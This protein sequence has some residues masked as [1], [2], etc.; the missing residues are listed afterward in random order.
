MSPVRILPGDVLKRLRDLPDESVHCVVTSPPY[1]GLRN[2]GI[3]PTIWEPVRYSPMAGL[4]EMPVPVHA[5]PESFPSCNHDWGTRESRHVVREEKVSGKTRTTD[6]F[7]GGDPTRRFDGNHQKHVDGVFC[8][9]CGAWSGC[10]GNEPTPELFVGHIVQVFREVRR[11]LRSDGTLW[12][13]IGDSYMSSGGPNKKYPSRS[14]NPKSVSVVR[15]PEKNL[16]MI[17]SRVAMALQSDGWILRS[18]IL[19]AKQNGMPESIKDRPTCAHEKI[20]LFSRSPRYFYDYEGAKEPANAKNWHDMTSS[21]SYTAPGQK[22]Q[23]M[24]LRSEVQNARTQW[25]TI[26]DRTIRRDLGVPRQRQREAGQTIEY[27]TRNSRNVWFMP[28]QPFPEAHYA[29][30]PEELPR[31]AILA[32]TPLHVCPKCGEPRNTDGCPENLSGAATVLDPFGGSGTT[33]LV[34]QELG[35]CAVLIE[36]SP[37]NVEMA[38]RRILQSNPLFSDIRIV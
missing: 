1:F 12:L 24:H 9:K 21:G 14:V 25:K 35:R 8:L 5:D 3:D 23:K 17:P 15:L 19:W 4:P 31:R 2:Y 34:A 30:F 13:N 11:V 29:T 32:G 16:F 37:E 27:F 20:F 36:A 18:E 26:T 28:T 33:G 38:R 6:R 7:Y 22:P 10:L